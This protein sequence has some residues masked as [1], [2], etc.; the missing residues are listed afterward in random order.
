MWCR[1]LL[2]CLQL[3]NSGNILKLMVPFNNLK[4]ISVWELKLLENTMVTTVRVATIVF[5]YSCKVI[6]HKMIER[7]IDNRGS[8]SRVNINTFVKEQRAD[9]SWQVKSNQTLLSSRCLACLRYA[10]MGFERNFQIRTFSKNKNILTNF[11]NGP[12]KRS[13][14]KL[15]TLSR[16]SRF[17]YEKVLENYNK[18]LFQIRVYSTK[19]SQSF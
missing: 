4:I 1:I 5:N 2:S 9:G 14:L 8:K 11:S 13:A 12:L 19:S 18:T 17:Y 7:K 6:I 10:L 16:G 15:G 3:S